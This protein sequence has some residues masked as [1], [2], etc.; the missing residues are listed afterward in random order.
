MNLFGPGDRQAALDVLLARARADDLVV[1][2]ALTGSAAAGAADSW[3]DI[4]LFLGVLDVP[5][6]LARWSEF[7]HAEL[8]AVHH[9]DLPAGATVYRAFL[10]HNGLEVD[11]GLAPT[12]E[13]GPVG[14]GAFQVLFGEATAR[15]STATDVNHLVGL[16]WHHV[17]HARTSIERGKPWRAEYWISAL[18]DHTLTM[19]CVRLGLPSAYAKGADEL[20][21]DASAALVRDLSEAELWRAFRAATD[22]FVRELRHADPDSRL[23]P[24]LLGLADRRVHQAEQVRPSSGGPVRPR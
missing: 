8:G 16:C 2:A 9:F 24:V 14:D 17:L 19:A 21:D 6:A 7:V 4:D 12:A 13:F 3:S 15:R 18:R 23:A 20:P 1:G 11:L 22:G 5:V 10:L